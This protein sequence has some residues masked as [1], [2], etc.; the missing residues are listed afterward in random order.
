M[1][2]CHVGSKGRGRKGGVRGPHKKEVLFTVQ[3]G[4]PFARHHRH[5]FSGTGGP[6]GGSTFRVGSYK[7]TRDDQGMQNSRA[8]AFRGWNRQNSHCDYQNYINGRHRVYTTD[9]RNSS[10]PN[11]GT[12][13]FL[14]PPLISSSY[15]RPHTY[16]SYIFLHTKQAL[17][18][19]LM[20][21]F[22][23]AFRT[24][25]LRTSQT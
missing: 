12:V 6:P 13:F 21:C 14:V 15:L 9:T 23:V 8:L 24:S 1:G 22:Q 10:A 16:I 25:S 11:S 5:P 7:V 17:P 3:F 4:C 2:G 20:A 19:L 18:V